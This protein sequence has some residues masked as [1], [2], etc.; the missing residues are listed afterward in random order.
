MKNNFLMTIG[1]ES[2][3]KV[4]YRTYP[5]HINC[6][7]K[8]SLEFIH[9][10]NLM[11]KDKGHMSICRIIYDIYHKFYFDLL[12]KPLSPKH[13]EAYINITGLC[14]IIFSMLSYS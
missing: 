8:G 12:W 11:G 3:P 10:L 6:H 4:L 13:I 2:F 7:I 9:V 5:P 14:K 1:R